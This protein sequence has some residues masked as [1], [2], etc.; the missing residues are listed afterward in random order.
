MRGQSCEQPYARIPAQDRVVVAGGAQ[1][2]GFGVVF[3]RVV[4]P[5]ARGDRGAAI[6][7][8]ELRD[9][10]TLADQAGVLGAL[11][12]AGELRHEIEGLAVRPGALAELIGQR[13]DQ[14]HQRGLMNLIDGEDVET[15]AFGLF[16]L[17][18]QPVALGF[19]DG[20]GQRIRREWLQVKHDA[21]RLRVS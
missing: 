11:V 20:G 5:F 4:E 1:R 8:F 7:V 14:H 10:A 15:D 6:G 2:L 18:E 21:P 13:E 19:V 9:G 12:G 16:G 3:E 17:A